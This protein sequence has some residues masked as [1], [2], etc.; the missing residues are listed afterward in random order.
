MIGPLAPGAARRPHRIDGRTC[1]PC[2]SSCHR[3][4]LGERSTPP[5][6]TPPSAR[7]F[8]PRHRRRTGA[9][10]RRHLPQ[11]FRREETRRRRAVTDT[12]LP[13]SPPGLASTAAAILV[14]EGKMQWTPPPNTSPPA[15]RCSRQ[16]TRD[17][18]RPARPSHRLSAMT[19]FVRHQLDPRRSSATSPRRRC[20]TVPR[21]LAVS[22]HHVSPPGSRGSGQRRRVGDVRQPFSTRS[23]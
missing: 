15:Q 7:R 18:A 8:R 1:V 16:C 21:R 19:R 20:Q 5:R 17:H 2:P 4:F 6:W 22:E 14:D 3:L 10:Q 11:G 23:A 12:P 9:R 13:S